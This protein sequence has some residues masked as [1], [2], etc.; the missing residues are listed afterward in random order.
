[1][2]NRKRAS[3]PEIGAATRLPAYASAPALRGTDER[4]F[5]LVETLVAMVAALLVLGATVTL[6]SSSQRIQTRDAEWALTM[7]QDRVGLARMVR[8]IRQATKVKAANAGSI[9][10]LATIGGKEYE[11]KYECETV[12]STE[13]REC[14]RLAAEKGK[15]LP[16]SGLVV[17]TD[18]LNGTSVF[19]YSPS[20]ASPRAAIV[21]LELPAKGTLKQVSSTGFQH[22]IVL[23]DAAFMRNLY[24]EG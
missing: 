12:Q 18:L 10:F 3:R 20:S 16:T 17:A 9:F 11:V 21:K 8:D 2:E 13:F 5:T 6:L 4:G 14:V 23:E 19:T 15:T 22:K 24:L 1:M 7:Q